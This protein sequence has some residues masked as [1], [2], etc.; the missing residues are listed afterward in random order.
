MQCDSQSL[1]TNASS[2]HN[3]VPDGMRLA[4]V[5]SLLC[6]IANV[7]C[8]PQ[9]LVNNA[10]CQ[11]SCLSGDLQGAIVIYLLC[12]IA[13]GGGGGN[14]GVIAANYGGNQPNFTPSTTGA[15]AIDTSTGQIWWWYNN[16]WN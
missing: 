1:A 2:I 9:S 8:D 3:S 14:A 15:V 5:I 7:N 12:Q 13:S 10:T 6:Q 4:V 16:Q 11:L